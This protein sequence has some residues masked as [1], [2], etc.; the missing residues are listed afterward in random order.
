MKRT[1]AL[2]RFRR[3]DSDW[4]GLRRSETTALAVA[5]LQQRD[6]RWV[7]C[8]LLGK[9]GRVHSVPIAAWIQCAIDRWTEAAAITEG[10]IFRRVNRHGTVTG[11]RLSDEG[12]Y[13]DRLR[14]ASAAEADAARRAA[15]I[16]AAGAQA[17]APL[18]QTQ[19]SL[20]HASVE[21]TERYLGTRLDLADAP[22][23][24]IRLHLAE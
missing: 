3:R 9:G 22:S 16:C 23:D 7:I 20:G 4:P 18:E 21:T 6:G 12:V 10:R 17:H 19:L 11:E 13:G 1:T 8:D 14:G 2:S 5:H 24:R 15:H